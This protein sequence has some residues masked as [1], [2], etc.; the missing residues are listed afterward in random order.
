MGS[1]PVRPGDISLAEL[2]RIA[3]GNDSI[4]LAEGRRKG[5][6]LTVKMERSNTE[7]YIFR[8]LQMPETIEW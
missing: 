4:A 1:R 6:D 8:N 5:V 2:C 7:T 3:R